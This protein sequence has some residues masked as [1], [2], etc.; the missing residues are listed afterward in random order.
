MIGA[1]GATRDA[2]WARALAGEPRMGPP[3]GIDESVTGLRGVVVARVRDTELR[4]R[5]KTLDDH[6]IPRAAA[7]RYRQM[8][9]VA[10]AEAMAD[11]GLVEQAGKTSG[12]GAVVMGGIASGTIE[13]E[14][15]ALRVHAG[16]RPRMADNM[17]KRTSIAVQD[18]ARVCGARGPAFAVDAACT[19][20][21]VALAQ[22]RRLIAAGDADWCL[23]GGA[24]ASLTATHLMPARS[25]RALTTRFMQEP[26]RAS[27]PFDTKRCGFVP[28]EGACFVLLESADR[29]AARGARVYAELAASTE[30]VDVSHP[31]QL[32]AGFIQDLMRSVL[33]RAGASPNEVSWIKAHATSTPQGDATEAR[34]IAA[35]FG[36]NDV[37]VSAPKSL[38]G[39]MMAASGA[40]EAALAAMSIYRGIIPPTINLDTQ[41]PTCPVR[42][43]TRPTEADVSMVL[44]NSFGFGGPGVC[45]MLRKA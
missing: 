16:R 15:I 36:Q 1:L 5:L 21:A 43:V 34:A 41:D 11:A 38:T 24:E 7:G 27:R 18:V 6:G 30:G 19:S 22:G 8:A 32:E 40:L 31:T 10:A 45:L 13:V 17:G 4:E 44:C 37:N 26:H 23:A 28:A 12:C 14:R 25:L 9:A 2:A 33:E 42:V 39:H 3:R 35:V 29:A 20:G